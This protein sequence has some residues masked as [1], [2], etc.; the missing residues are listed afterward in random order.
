MML[1]I[2]SDDATRSV[3]SGRRVVNQ[4][5]YVRAPLALFWTCSLSD[6]TSFPCHRRDVSASGIAVFAP[7]DHASA[8]IN[9]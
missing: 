4:R 3:S 9:L 1:E 6:A 5:R 8:D 7:K 2:P